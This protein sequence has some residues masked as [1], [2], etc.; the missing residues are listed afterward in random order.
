M[1]GCSPPQ[2][3]RC[4]PA[5]EQMQRVRLPRRAPLQLWGGMSN[6]LLLQNG[7]AAAGGTRLF[8][9]SSAGKSGYANLHEETAAVEAKFPVFGC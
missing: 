5:S 1:A 2:H 4:L 8:L 9:A 7:Q 3:P 6:R